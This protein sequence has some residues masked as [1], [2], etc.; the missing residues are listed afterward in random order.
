MLAVINNVSVWWHV[1]GAAAVIVILFLVPEQHASFGEVFA[2][3]INNSG[4][5][6]GSTSGLGLPAL[7]AADLGDPDPVHDHGL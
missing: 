5:F 1:A 4:M 3:T 2:K 6:G 7:R